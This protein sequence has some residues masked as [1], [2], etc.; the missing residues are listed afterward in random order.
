[1]HRLRIHALL[2]S[3]VL[4][5]AVAAC[6][7]SNSNITETGAKDGEGVCASVDTDG[8]DLLAEVCKRDT[9]LASTDPAY[10]PQSSLN[11]DT[12]QYEGFDID[13]AVEIGRRLGVKEVEWTA[14]DFTLITSGNWN[15]RWDMSVGSITVLPSRGEVLYFTVPYYY[16]P[17][18]VAVNAEN[19]SVK[20]VTTDLDGKKIGVCESCSYDFYLQKEL[21]APG[22]TYDFV[23]DD[24]DRVTYDTDSTAIQDLALGDGTRLDAAI[25]ATPTLQAAVDAGSDIK[26]VDPA[27]F[28][29]ALAVAFDKS[30]SPDA[31]TLSE[32]VS[33]IIEEMHSDGT[34]TALSKKWY[35]GQDLS[36]LPES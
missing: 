35:D 28:F 34:L 15:G 7:G 19:T 36:T 27:L 24:P 4:L 11:Q 14:P 18:G 13:V 23:I 8:G 20:D 2:A 12:N 1:M 3:A 29:E 5:A 31:Q 30:A 10:P 26:I 21:S 33:T 22:V 17:A 9:L 16:T 32:A 25:S 6:G